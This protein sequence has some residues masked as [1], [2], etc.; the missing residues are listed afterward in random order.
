M[1]E[2]PSHVRA[3]DVA[4]PDAGVLGRDKVL[5]SEPPLVYPGCLCAPRRVRPEHSLGLF[6]AELILGI[7]GVAHAQ[8]VHSF[9]D[10]FRVYVGGS[11]DY[12]AFLAVRSGFEQRSEANLP[13]Q[14]HKI[15]VVEHLGVWYERVINALCRKL[16]RFVKSIGY[17]R[18]ASRRMYTKRRNIADKSGYF[19]AKPVSALSLEL[20]AELPEPP[21]V[22][23]KSCVFHIMSPFPTL[24]VWLLLTEITEFIAKYIKF[25]FRY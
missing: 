6:V 4:Q 19:G 8:R 3:Y 20:A 21:P 25:S 14:R 1:G 16:V 10:V 9:V 2:E 18:K 5:G 13:H 15:G 17:E 23:I 12:I 7:T 11:I 22:D 24:Q